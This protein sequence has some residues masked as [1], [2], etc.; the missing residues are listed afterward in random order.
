MSSVNSVGATS[1]IASTSL[2]EMKQEVKSE[3]DTDFKTEGD[4]VINS[5]NCATSGKS[6]NNN[7]APQ[8]V[9]GKC[10]PSVEVKM[11]TQDSDSNSVPIK[12]EQSA[13]ASGSESTTTPKPEGMD[14]TAEASNNSDDSKSNMESPA[15]GTA[16]SAAAGTS[17]AGTVARKPNKKKGKCNGHLDLVLVMF[18]I[19]SKISIT[20]PKQYFFFFLHKYSEKHF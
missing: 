6:A 15:A 3:M 13:T 5:T 10:I 8:N 19:V 2:K 14:S 9:S 4:K 20:A 11:E 12:E 17:A 16:T 7:N 1:N 18:E